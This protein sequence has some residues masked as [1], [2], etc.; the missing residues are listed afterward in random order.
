MLRLPADP[1]NPARSWRQELTDRRQHDGPGARAGFVGE[2]ASEADALSALFA[3]EGS[4]SLRYDLGRQLE[5]VRDATGAD[6]SEL[7]L[8]EPSGGGMV[9][10]VHTGPFR[11]AFNDPLRFA[12]G[13]GF[14]GR[15][16]VTGELALTED[17]RNDPSYLRQRVKE[18]G[19]QVYMCAPLR[20][21]GEVVGSVGLAYK[22]A[23]DERLERARDLLTRLGGPMGAL[24]KA[25][26]AER[27]AELVRSATPRALPTERVEALLRR[28]MDVSGAHAGDVQLLHGSARSGEPARAAT[29]VT[30]GPFPDDCRTCREGHFA[31]CPVLAYHRGEALYGRRTAWPAPCRSCAATGGL[32]LC[33]PVV[34]D[35]E[36]IGLVRLWRRPDRGELPSADLVLVET[37][38]AA[39]SVVM[40]DDRRRI[41]APIPALNLDPLRRARERDEA[42]SD[43]SEGR[44]PGEARRTT[45]PRPAGEAASSEAT[46]PHLSVRAFGTFEL[47]VGGVPVKVS[48]VGRRRTLTL[49]KMLIA[50]DGRPVPRDVLVENLWPGGDPQA[51]IGQLYVLVHELRRLIDP[52]DGPGHLTCTDGRYHFDPSAA[53]WVDVRAYQAFAQEASRADERGDTARAIAT[54]GAAV[55]LYRG[56]FMEDEPYA[57][58]CQLAR[59]QLRESCLGLLRRLADHAAEEQDWPRSI[60]FLR[61]AVRLEPLREE[62]HRSL[63]LVF[64]RAGRRVE[65]LQQYRTCERLLQAELGVTP[66]PATRKLHE[67]IR[68]EAQAPT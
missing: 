36:P 7:Y 51:K 26:L 14:P 3:F 2:L 16:L 28:F 64:W 58:W 13:A 15:V 61:A 5:H 62:T 25:A 67:T 32:R 42:T 8:T 12:R 59:E 40:D 68:L 29:N 47:R 66:L 24:V 4:G 35:G 46:E 10:T 55:D 39:V 22:H 11:Q 60:A 33:V 53:A 56:D 20:Y 23:N 52:T 17:V 48:D 57:A 34:V 1:L 49:L 19:F 63:M 50:H 18:A 65:A 54:A 30:L 44:T 9:L 38:A 43:R 41:H 45:G 27:C 6:V 21:A 37:M 31:D